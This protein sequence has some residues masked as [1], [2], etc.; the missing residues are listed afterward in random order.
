MGGNNW[1]QGHYNYNLTL[2]FILLKKYLMFKIT[3]VN[4]KIIPH[5]MDLEY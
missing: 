1:I 5:R 4:F 2:D 3:N